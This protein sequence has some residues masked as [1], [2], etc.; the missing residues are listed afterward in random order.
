MSAIR[1]KYT[2]LSVLIAVVANV[3]LGPVGLFIY[4]LS[5]AAIIHE[6]CTNVDMNIAAQEA[7]THA[8]T[9][10]RAGGVMVG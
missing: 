2:M 6:Y 1:V 4:D 5:T 10:A 9:D 3:P 8:G 7:H